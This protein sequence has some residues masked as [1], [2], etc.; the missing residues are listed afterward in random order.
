MRR[1]RGCRLFLP[2]IPSRRTPTGYV[3]EASINLADIGVSTP[4]QP[5]QTISWLVGV[6]D[7]DVIDGQAQPLRRLGRKSLK[8]IRLFK[9]SAVE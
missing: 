7:Y 5:G 1:R 3:V 6:N 9:V 8:G 4:V 2:A